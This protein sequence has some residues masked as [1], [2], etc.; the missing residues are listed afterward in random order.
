MILPGT[1]WVF[2]AHDHRALKMLLEEVAVI[3]SEVLQT[4]GRNA[5]SLARRYSA[6]NCADLVIQS[7]HKTG[8][9]PEERAPAHSAT[10]SPELGS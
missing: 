2:P 8:V 7:L 10:G 1:G 6:D 4:M 5:E 9:L 3:R